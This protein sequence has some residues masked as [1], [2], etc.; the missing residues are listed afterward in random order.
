MQETLVREPDGAMRKSC[1]LLVISKISTFQV[2]ERKMLGVRRHGQ[3]L[4]LDWMQSLV[5]HILSASQT[6]WAGLKR[7]IIVLLKSWKK[8]AVLDETMRER[9]WQYR[10]IFGIVLLLARTTVI[11]SYEY[12]TICMH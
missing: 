10:Q 8:K 1:F 4:F 11:L 7:K 9:W 3:I 12:M 2:I 5:L 6:E